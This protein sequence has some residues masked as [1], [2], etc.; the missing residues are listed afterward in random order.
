MIKKIYINEWHNLKPY[1]STVPTDI[2]YL[3]LS[4][5]IKR[6]LKSNEQAFIF[7]MYLE[8]DDIDM[9]SC[10][11]CSYFEDI[12]SETNIWNSFVT[13]HKSKYNKILPFYELENYIEKEINNQDIYFLIWYFINTIQVSKF[14]SPFNDFIYFSGDKIMEIFEREWDKAPINEHLQSFYLLNDDETD[15][16]KV[17]HLIDTIL[18]KTYLFIPD[19]GFK[20]LQ[21]EIELFDKYKDDEMLLN[22]LKDNR[23]H[24]LHKIHTRLLSLKGNE[25]AQEIVKQNNQINK[26]LFDIS[27]KIEGYFLYKGQDYENL[28]IEHI[29]SGKE[30]LLTK[31]S[32]DYSDSLKEIDEII[33]LGMVKWRNEWWFSGVSFQ[34]SFDADLILNEK[35][36]L[37]SRSAVNFID[38]EQFNTTDLLNNQLLI[39]EAFNKG[40]QIAFLKTS[41]I[42]KFNSDYIEFYNKS[43]NL[44]HKEK[45]AARDRAKKDGLFLKDTNFDFSDQGENGLVFMNPKS[46]CEIAFDINSAFPL[47]MNPFYNEAESEEHILH[48]LINE[49]LSKE[50]ALF[51]IEHCKNKLPFFKVGLGK[52]YLKD[53]DFLLRFWKT[54]NYHTQPLITYTGTNNK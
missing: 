49:N 38:H 43:L 24:S 53:M 1:K 36:S 26:E 6:I 8:D 40:S 31:K 54:S 10:F 34:Q 42:D 30:F 12:I 2:Y 18:F 46:G 35:N 21:S 27:K 32:Y 52:A 17:R 16:Y 48:L 28:K 37:S 51:C 5:E 23:D 22:L 25:W 19:T 11:L 29:A 4:N 15:Y 45:K 14:I 7:Q 41:D 44:S 50:L 39:F 20:L 33:H 13:I 47:P 3:K 9:L